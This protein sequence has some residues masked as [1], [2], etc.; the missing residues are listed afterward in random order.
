MPQERR[1]MRH[2]APF[3]SAP[4]GARAAPRPRSPS[5]FAPQ[6][7]LEFQLAVLGEAPPSEACLIDEDQLKLEPLV[8]PDLRLPALIQLNTVG[9]ENLI[10]LAESDEHHSAIGEPALT[11]LFTEL[12]VCPLNPCEVELKS[13]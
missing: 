13:L 8:I 7:R 2:A 9:L 3:A 11:T 6:R 12:E 5:L 4:T 1:P 10:R